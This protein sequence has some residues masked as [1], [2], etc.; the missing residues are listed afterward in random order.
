MAANGLSTIHTGNYW[1]GAI[2]PFAET[3]DGNVRSRSTDTEIA[4]SR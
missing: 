4:A 1:G 2:T 3:A